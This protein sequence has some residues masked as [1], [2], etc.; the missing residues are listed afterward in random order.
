ML[1]SFAPLV[2]SIIPLWTQVYG[3]ADGSGSWCWIQDGIAYEWAWALLLMYAP[4]WFS[5]IFIVVCYYKL[6]KVLKHEVHEFQ[7]TLNKLYWFPAIG[8]F[9]YLF[10]TLHR[11]YAIIYHDTMFLMVLHIL[12]AHSQGTFN[13]IYYTITKGNSVKAL[14]EYIKSCGNVPDNDNAESFF[15]QY[16]KAKDRKDEKDDDTDSVSNIV[17]AYR[18]MSSVIDNDKNDSVYNNNVY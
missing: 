16:E 1:C 11:F 18:R 8:G 9:C 17:K 3:R 4:F 14:W 10:A 12:I 13:A 5:L 6:T 15:E 7:D 2:L